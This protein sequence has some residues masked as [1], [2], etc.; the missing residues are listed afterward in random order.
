MPDQTHF[1]IP[2]ISLTSKALVESAF[3]SLKMENEKKM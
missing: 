3:K 2:S 1:S